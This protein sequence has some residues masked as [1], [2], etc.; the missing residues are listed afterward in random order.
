MNLSAHGTTSPDPSIA[1]LLKSH[2]HKNHGLQRHRLA[3]P[4]ALPGKICPDRLA[5]MGVP[6]VVVFIAWRSTPCHQAHARQ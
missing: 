2:T 4:Q 1:S 3:Q 5:A 6:P